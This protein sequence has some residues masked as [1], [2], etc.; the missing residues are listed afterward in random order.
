MTEKRK[1]AAVM[2][3]DIAGYTA[4]M[5]KDE[6]K[7]LSILEKNRT[8]QK[9]LAK[10][11]NG[12]FLKEM[13]D[14]TLLCF[15]SALD[16]VRCA[17]AIQE[18]VKDEPD[19]NLRIGIHLGDIVFKEG[20]V[21]GDGVN[22]ASRIEKAARPGTICFSAPVYESIK[23]KPGIRAEYLE[24]KHLKHVQGP[25]DIFIINAEPIPQQTD[26]KKN[27]EGNRKP[28]NWKMIIPA[29]I[30]ITAALFILL[31]KNPFQRPD[32]RLDE[33]WHNSVAVLPFSDLSP[34]SD[35]E[36]FCE[37]MMDDIILKLLI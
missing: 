10:K 7:A 17:M 23:N 14:G 35:Q 28:L 15:S 16:A 36:Y 11:H 2:F 33:T 6:Q 13:G 3:T 34:Q 1:L 32:G 24:P 31:L 9:S 26:K 22:V 25:L 37:G 27:F 21:F 8:L 30:V 19:L 12:E 18:S 4:M 20:D 5:E 29:C